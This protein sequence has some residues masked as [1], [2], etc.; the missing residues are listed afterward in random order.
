MRWKCLGYKEI[1]IV[2]H[3]EYIKRLGEINYVIRERLKNLER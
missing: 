1:I 2:L 3:E